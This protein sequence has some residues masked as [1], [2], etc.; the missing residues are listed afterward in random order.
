MSLI[1]DLDSICINSPCDISRR[2]EIVYPVFH[3]KDFTFKTIFPTFWAN[4]KEN[5][6]LVEYELR[7][8]LKGYQIQTELYSRSVN[9]PEPIG[10]YTMNWDNMNECWNAYAGEFTLPK[11][12]MQGIPG[13]LMRRVKGLCGTRE[14][15]DFEEPDLVEAEVDKARRLGYTPSSD[16]T[17]NYLIE[18]REKSNATQPSTKPVVL[19]DFDSWKSPFSQQNI[20]G[21][22]NR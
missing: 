13:M 12:D 7:R 15:K 22:F 10:M 6:Q 17:W 11:E 1:R 2:G 3:S 4:R 14:N 21:G 8:I 9:V 5:P 20:D 16:Y 18:S 19:I